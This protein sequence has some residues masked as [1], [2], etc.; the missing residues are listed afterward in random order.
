M[1]APCCVA[2]SASEALLLGQPRVVGFV[3]AFY[4]ILAAITKPR[5]FCSSCDNTTCLPAT[6]VF[7]HELTPCESRDESASRDA[8]PG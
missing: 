3:R 1:L 5:V 4:S 8:P 6:R 2:R 7:V